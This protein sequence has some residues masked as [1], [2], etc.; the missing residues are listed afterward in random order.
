MKNYI[1]LTILVVLGFVS[2]K[3]DRE[4]FIV[5]DENVYTSTIV[6]LVT[7]ENEDPISG[8]VVDYKGTTT[9]QMLMDFTKLPTYRLATF[10]IS[11]PLPSP[12]ILKDAERLEP[13]KKEVY[14]PKHNYWPCNLMQASKVQVEEILHQMV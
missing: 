5:N 8:A 9:S 13:I 2:C 6:G 1:I 14:I 4:E 11:L 3:K 7:D 12:G 10:I